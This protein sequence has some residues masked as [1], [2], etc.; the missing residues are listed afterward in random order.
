MPKYPS[1]IARSALILSAALLSALAVSPALALSSTETPTIT[2]TAP[3]FDKGI[4]PV[5]NFARL[6]AKE[7]VVIS[8]NGKRLAWIDGTSLVTF[9][10]DSGEQNVLGGGSNTPMSV[11][12]A[13]DDYLILQVRNQQRLDSYDQL[14]DFATYLIVDAKAKYV[15]PLFAITGSDK[16]SPSGPVLRVIGGDNPYA[17][18]S[19]IDSNTYRP[20]LSTNSDSYVSTIY[21]VYLK[22]GKKEVGERGTPNTDYWALDKNGVGRVRVESFQE[23]INYSALRVRVQVRKTPGSNYEDFVVEQKPDTIARSFKYSD[24]D[25]SVFWTEYNTKT[26]M[27]EVYYRSIEGGETKLFDK[28][29]GPNVSVIIEA[30]TGKRLGLGTYTDRQRIQWTDPFYKAV[31]ASMEKA[32]PGR[33]ITLSNYS[34]D[35]SAI[36]VEAQAPEAP[37]VY[38]LYDTRTKSLDIIGES[39]PELAGARLG[40]TKYITYKASDGLEIPAYVTKRPDIKS[41]APLVL[42]V[43]GGPAARDYYGFDYWPQYLANQGYVVLQ[44]QYRGSQGFG[45]AFQKAGNKNLRRMIEDSVDGVKYLVDQ[46]LVDPKRVCI[47]GWS[48]GGY[49]TMAALTMFPDVW[50]CGVEGAGVADPETM[51]DWVAQRAGGQGQKNSALNYW[52]SVMGDPRAEAERVKIGSPLYNLANMKAP[53][54]LV[55]GEKDTVVPIEQSEIMWSAMQKA[56]KPGKFVRL[57][58]ED[59]HI[60]LQKSRLTFLTEM[61]AFLKAHLDP[62]LQKSDPP[63]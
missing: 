41:P 22:T 53:M 1:T 11:R 20:G 18:V 29:A 25:N 38:Y 49:S 51:I 46:G 31:Y 57:P 3:H 21:K 36:V 26:N 60:T 48:W 61:G 7:S 34:D 40:E 50:T 43:H 17:L 5:E 10:L 19:G 55:H 45:D 12:W 16:P 28:V 39:Y 8:P 33:E 30:K 6:S 59:H 44:P 42:V 24:D 35:K 32:L 23:R 54:L 63:K 47:T 58:D 14:I 62:D 2:V 37:P 9:D 52:K 4:A 56:G 15:G 13:G 27:S